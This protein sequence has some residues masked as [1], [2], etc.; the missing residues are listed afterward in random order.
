MCCREDTALTA[1]HGLPFCSDCAEGHLLFAFV[2]T[3][4]R[5]SQ[6]TFILKNVSVYW[7]MIMVA[8]EVTA[9]TAFRYE[10]SWHGR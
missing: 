3:I 7:H 4:F 10:R 6:S 5:M 8:V 2:V 9:V 1:A